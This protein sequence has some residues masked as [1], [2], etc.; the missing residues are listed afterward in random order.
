MKCTAPSASV[1]PFDLGCTHAYAA[2]IT[3]SR[4]AGM[5]IT[6]ADG[7]IAAIAAANGFA[8]AS[9]DAGALQAVGVTVIDPRQPQ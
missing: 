7:C 8:V 4:R 5:A 1:L 9:R 3:K 6:M 2:L